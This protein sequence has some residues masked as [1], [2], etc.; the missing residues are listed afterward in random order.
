MRS[1]E[2]IMRSIVTLPIAIFFATIHNLS[3]EGGFYRDALIYSLVA[4]VLN[5]MSFVINYG[6]DDS[7]YYVM[8]YISFLV[9]VYCGA[10]CID[11]FR[12]H[13]QQLFDNEIRK[14]KEL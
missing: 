1:I 13:K 5:F 6:S 9:S 8:S 4:S 3:L 10:N 14:L 7:F 11:L 12:K 2:I